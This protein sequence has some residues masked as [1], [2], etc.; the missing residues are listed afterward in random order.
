MIKISDTFDKNTSNERSIAK[1]FGMLGLDLENDEDVILM[2]SLPLP[3]L[4]MTGKQNDKT[5]HECTDEHEFIDSIKKRQSKINES[6]ES[7]DQQR[8]PHEEIEQSSRDAD[9]EQGTNIQEDS[10]LGKRDKPATTQIDE[11]NNDKKN[12]EKKTRRAKYPNPI[13]MEL[14]GENFHD[15]TKLVQERYKSITIE[16]AEGRP[17]VEIQT[18]ELFRMFMKIN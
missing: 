2:K 12:T 8:N 9:Q 4:L 7:A 14:D 3:V 6:F 10:N 1:F 13:T 16:Y 5:K 17:P 11:E 18:S 15:W